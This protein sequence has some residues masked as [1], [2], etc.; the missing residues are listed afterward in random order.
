VA[1]VVATRAH[2]QLV[3]RVGDV[4]LVL[5]AV[6]VAHELERKRVGDAVV[7]DNAADDVVARVAAK[8]QVCTNAVTFS[9]R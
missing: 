5:V 8:A 1:G 4:E 2:R 9:V 7:L 6:G 3:V